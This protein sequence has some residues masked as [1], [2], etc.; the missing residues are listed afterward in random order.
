VSG[1][2]LSQQFGI[3]HVTLI[4]DFVAAGYGLLTLDWASEVVVINAAERTPGAPMC[5]IGQCIYCSQWSES[6]AELQMLVSACV[7][8]VQNSNAHIQQQISSSVRQ[9]T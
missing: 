3:E 9:A 4:N 1:A 6:F 5:A 7:N 8:A 2:A